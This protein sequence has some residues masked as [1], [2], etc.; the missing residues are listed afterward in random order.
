MRCIP[1]EPEFGDGQ[2]AEKA[3]WKALRRASLTTSSSLTPFRSGTAG[4]EHEIDILVSGP[5]SG[6]PP[7]RSKAAASR[8]ENG[9]WYQS[10]KSGP[11][12]IQSPVAQSQASMH[13]F[14]K[15]IGTQLG[16]PLTSR[17]A[18]MVCF[19][20]TDVPQD[21][22]MAGCPAVLGSGSRRHRLTGGRDPQRHRA[23]RRRDHHTG[24][25][26]PGT[27]RAQA[28]GQSGH[29]V[30]RATGRK[31]DRRLPRPPH[32]AP[33]S[34]AARHPFPSP[35]SDSPAVRAAARPGSPWRRRESS[36]KKE[37]GSASSATTRASASTCRT[38]SGSGATPSRRSPASSMNT[39][40]DWVCRT[41]W[42]PT[43][44]RRRC[45]GCSRSWHWTSSPNSGWT[46]SSL[47]KPRTL[48]PCGGRCSS[49][50]PRTTP[51]SMRSWTTDRTSTG[52]GAARHRRLKPS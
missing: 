49:L 10:D 1:D 52:A 2:V 40:S 32:R 23:G 17:F 20:Y 24:T 30:G 14:K 26:V 21:W 46:P 42:G 5:A 34:A 8:V 29:R 36:V 15:W 33:I 35:E 27:N 11:H 28:G 6:W 38:G 39:L 19:P 12:P 43:T 41:E 51:R 50:P 47:M 48:R 7:S 31:G 45:R 16:T 25:N 37:S 22:E 13:A 9:Q 18:Y 44:S 4:Q 3:V